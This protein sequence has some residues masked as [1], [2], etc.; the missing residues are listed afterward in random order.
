[1]SK[2]DAN[3]GYWQLPL[4]EESQLMTT[5]ITLLDN[6]AQLVGPFGLTSMPEIFGE[7][8]DALMQGVTRVAKSIDD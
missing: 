3:S 1:M 8:L 2:T 7:R 6:I 4:S 5:F